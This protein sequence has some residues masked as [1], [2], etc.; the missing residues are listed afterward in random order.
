MA[1]SEDPDEMQHKA[2]FHLGLHCLL[3]LKQPPGKEIHHNLE[4]ISI[5]MEN[6]I[7]I[8]RVNTWFPSKH[9][10]SKQRLTHFDATRSMLHVYFGN[11][12]CVLKNT[13]SAKKNI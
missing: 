6:S 2:A 13:F 10:L 5:C 9:E 7:R 4:I 11:V 1:N 3:R 8:Q 12:Q